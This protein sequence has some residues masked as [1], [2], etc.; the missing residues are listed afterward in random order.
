MVIKRWQVNPESPEKSKI[1]SEEYGLPNM[2]SNIFGGTRIRPSCCSGGV[3]NGTPEYADPFSV[4]DMDLAVE[5]I[6]QAID[7]GEKI[8]VYG[9]YDC[10]G[11]TATAILYQYFNS[12]GANVVYYIPERDGEGYGLNSGAVEQLAEQGVTLLVTVDNGISAVEEVLLAKRLGIDVIN[13]P[14]SAGRSA[15]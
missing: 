10:D 5:R 1:L 11:V 14:P 12:I 3:F 7:N 15:S 2:V 4:V 6:G 13:R 8:A 9:D